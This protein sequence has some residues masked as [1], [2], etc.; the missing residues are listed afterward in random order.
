MA[1]RRLHRAALF[2]W[3]YLPAQLRRWL[4]RVLYVHGPI[5]GVAI[6]T[7]EAGRVLF[8]HPTY[9]RDRNWSLPGGF[10]SYGERPIDT[11]RR[12]VREE[13]GREIDVA[14][15]LAEG[16]GDYGDVA[17]AYAASFRDP[18]SAIVL[19]DELDEYRYFARDALPPM[20]PPIARLVRAAL[21]QR[22][23]RSSAP[24]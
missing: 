19:S 24:E 5:G 3:K 4:V 11:V 23:A 6:I 7:D 21:K 8:V 20:A 14:G 2:T 1:S 18:A 17:F 15:L 13:L 9:R 22:D 12:E 16:S 10:T